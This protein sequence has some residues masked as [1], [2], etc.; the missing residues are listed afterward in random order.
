MKATEA[1]RGKPA[2]NRLPL[3]DITCKQCGQV[4]QVANPRRN[5]AKFCSRKCHYQF[6]KTINGRSHP[7]FNQVSKICLWCGKEFWVIQSR[8][9][10][11]QFC[12]YECHGAWSI[13]K[14]NKISKPEVIVNNALTNLGLAFE[15]QYRIGKYACDFV[16]LQYKLIIEVDGDYWH[17]LPQSIKRDKIKDI[18]LLKNGWTILR[19]KE[20]DIKKNLSKCLVR[21]NKYITLLS[22]N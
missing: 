4:F 16:L 3:I 6:N 1:L 13:R 8:K 22:S 21:L 10:K 20:K 9:T 12:C 7:Y 2:W 17:S 15:T 19:F 5:T 11:A 18:S 14:A